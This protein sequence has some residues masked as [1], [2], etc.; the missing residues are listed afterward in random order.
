MFLVLCLG[1]MGVL[2]KGTRGEVECISFGSGKWY[3]M[4]GQELVHHRWRSI[5]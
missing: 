5:A 2:A 1:V 3:P 4:R